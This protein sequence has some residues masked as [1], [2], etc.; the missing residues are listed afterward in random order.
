MEAIGTSDDTKEGTQENLEF[1]RIVVV[2]WHPKFGITTPIG[3][4]GIIGQH[5][6]VSK[7]NMTSFGV[8][9]YIL[10]TPLNDR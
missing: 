5:P 7:S 2:E 8:S 1:E 3:F 10:Y 4:L 6:S 9:L